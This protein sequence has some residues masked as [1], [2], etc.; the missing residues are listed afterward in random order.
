MLARSLVISTLLVAVSVNDFI[1]E[2][3]SDKV[4]WGFQVPYK[5]FKAVRTCH[6]MSLGFPQRS[7][8]GSYWLELT[9]VYRLH[10]GVCTL[11][12]DLSSHSREARNLKLGRTSQKN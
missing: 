10:R 11:P 7:D 6:A 12:I 8:L 5:R 9:K 3:A 2:L 4:R 1:L